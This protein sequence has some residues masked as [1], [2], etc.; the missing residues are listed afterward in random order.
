MTPQEILTHLSDK[1][2]RNYIFSHKGGENYEVL[3]ELER[4]GKLRSTP[5]GIDK[6]IKCYELKTK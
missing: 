5:C 2:T 3:E 4:Q 6:Q 1:K